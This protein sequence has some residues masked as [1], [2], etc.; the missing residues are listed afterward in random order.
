MC[1][2][3]VLSLENNKYYV[4]KTDN[5]ERRFAEHLHGQGRSAHW[6]RKHKPIRVI[7][8]FEDSDGLQEDK[9]TLSYMIRHGVDNV[10]GGPYVSVSLSED[11]MAHILLRV[12]MA[13]DLCAVCGSP[14]H[15]VKDCKQKAA[16]AK[17]RIKCHTCNSCHHFTEDCDI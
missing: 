1:V 7:E 11:T 2:V 9:I 10:R 16:V 13:C 5:L 12:R 17:T 6:T 8:T 3:Y 15:F 4:G 14:A